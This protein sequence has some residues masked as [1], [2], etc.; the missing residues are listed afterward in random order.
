[1]PKKRKFQANISD[2]HKYKNLQQNVVN[3][4]QKYFKSII[5]HNQVELFL[6]CKNGATSVSQS[7]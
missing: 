7:L 3:Q 5:H 4:I 6:G 2:K 1:M